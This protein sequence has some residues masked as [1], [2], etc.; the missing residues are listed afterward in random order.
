MIVAV[1]CKE[2]DDDDGTAVFEIWCCAF[3]KQ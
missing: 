1:N 3:G 2:Y